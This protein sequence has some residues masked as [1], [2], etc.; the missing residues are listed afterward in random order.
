MQGSGI[1]PTALVIGGSGFIGTELT[2]ALEETGFRVLAPSRKEFDLLNP[3]KFADPID[4][5]YI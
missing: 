2:A 4:V 1:A 5:I 3:P